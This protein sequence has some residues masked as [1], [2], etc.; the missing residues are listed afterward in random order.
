MTMTCSWLAAAAL[1]AA[2]PV[3]MEVRRTPG[4]AAYGLIGEVG[5]SPKPVVVVIAHDFGVMRSQPVYTESAGLLVARGYL[6]VVVEPPCHG[7]DAKPGEPPQIDGWRHRLE[8]GQDLIGPFTARCTAALD[9]LV[10]CKAID[11][12]R[13]AATGTSRGGFLAFHLA[14][15]EP[16]VRAVAASAPVADLLMLR[17]FA[18]PAGRD[19]AAALSL[20][21]LAPRLAG[22]PAWVGIGNYDLRVDTDSVIGFTRALV[23]EGAKKA[24]KTDPI[25]PVELVVG[26]TGG[27]TKVD[28]AGELMAD[29]LARQLAPAGRE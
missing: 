13:V 23:R 4:G 27:H 3:A 24:G 5:T 25:V 6:A 19:A 12:G 22:R 1:L 26:P 11:P 7:E 8:R 28:R 18:G 20:T 14:A 29:W 15:A 21:K 9:H 10:A 17:E 2:D 16:R